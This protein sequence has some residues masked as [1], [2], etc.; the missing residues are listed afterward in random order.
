MAP[1]RAP[2]IMKNTSLLNEK[3]ILNSETGID[4][5]FSSSSSYSIL[6]TIY[7]KRIIIKSK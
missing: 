7:D 4:S 1:I 6:H 2:A 3:S 5:F